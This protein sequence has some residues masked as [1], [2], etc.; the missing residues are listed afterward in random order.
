MEKNITDGPLHASLRRVLSEAKNLSWKPLQNTDPY[1]YGSVYT[2]PY[3]IRILSLWEAEPVSLKPL[4]KGL[5]V[6]THGAHKAA[7][8]AEKE[9]AYQDGLDRKEYIRIRIYGTVYT[10]P[11]LI[12]VLSLGGV[13]GPAQGP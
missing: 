11:Y 6:I 9:R 4:Q 2:D 8:K 5:G 10:E 7:L 12:G 13:S 1:I 3:M